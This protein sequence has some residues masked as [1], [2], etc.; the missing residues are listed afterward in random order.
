MLYLSMEG[1]EEGEGKEEREGGKTK[2]ANEQPSWDFKRRIMLSGK[3]GKGD[4][5]C[6][7]RN[8]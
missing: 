3:A 5:N 4:S 6:E 7:V 1:K 2:K 8:R